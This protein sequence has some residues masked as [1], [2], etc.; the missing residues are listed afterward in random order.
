MS[1]HP[2]RFAVLGLALSFVAIL[3]TALPA[4]GGDIIDPAGDILPTFAPDDFTGPAGGD[5]DVLFATVLWNPTSQRFLL[6]ARFNGTI[7]TSQSDTG[8]G[9]AYAIGFDRGG[10]ADV[11]GPGPFGDIGSPDI[12]FNAVVGIN[13]DG[14]GAV[15]GVGPPAAIDPSD[16]QILGDRFTVQLDAALL[17]STG[18]AFEDYTWNLWPRI[19]FGN[20]NQISD[21]A[22]NN[23]MERVQAVP[24][25]SSIV[26]L[27]FGA[28]AL[29]AVGWKRFRAG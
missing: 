9:A 28:A 25:P 7:G 15:F 4:R 1:I 18:F 12:K 20:N 26:L 8:V 17:P 14:T 13:A 10:A 6:E 5:L 16:I 29:G 11:P 27:G 24:E 19:G 23:A 22:P 2:G 3:A 21:F